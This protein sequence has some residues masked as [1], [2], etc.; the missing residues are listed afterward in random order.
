MSDLKNT[1]DALKIKVFSHM[2]EAD[3]LVDNDA[4]LATWK[5]AKGAKRFDTKT[6]QSE[7]PE[8]Y[9]KYLK[10]GEP[11]RRFLIK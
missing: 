8:M 7:Q 10:T 5:S 1:E 4:I 11:A 6:F 2:G 3:T 9:A